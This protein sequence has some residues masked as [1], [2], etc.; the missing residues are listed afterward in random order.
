MFIDIMDS[1][2]FIFGVLGAVLVGRKNRIGFL[3]FVLH[4]IAA[5]TVGIYTGMYGLVGVSIVFVAIDLYYFR[6]WGKKD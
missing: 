4:S 3:M 2:V 6:Q 1:I 5:A